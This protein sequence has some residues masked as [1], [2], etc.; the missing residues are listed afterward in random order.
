M[1][2][3]NLSDFV[4]NGKNELR[5]IIK[6]Y[7]LIGKAEKGAKED[8]DKYYCTS[9]P[10]NTTVKRWIQEFKFG[11]T[12]TNYDPCSGRSSGATTPE[13]IKQI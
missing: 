4:N 9:A 5:V 10:S 7:Y 8:L 12:S 2:H 1:T 6:H 13:I 11:C 3:H